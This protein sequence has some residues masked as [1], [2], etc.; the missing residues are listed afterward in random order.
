MSEYKFPY[1]SPYQGRTHEPT[2]WEIALA[3]ALESA[4]TEGAYEVDA[5]VAA[6]NASRVRPREGGTWTVEGFTKTMQEL[7]SRP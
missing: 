4:F 7:E 3:G 2:D 1:L 6:L 5:L